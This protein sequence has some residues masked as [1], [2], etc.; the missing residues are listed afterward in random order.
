MFG[1]W[2]LCLRGTAYLRRSLSKIHWMH[3]NV[4]LTFN[5]RTAWNMKCSGCQVPR[6]AYIRATWL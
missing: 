2:S 1:F 4:S 3:I 5:Y 6:M